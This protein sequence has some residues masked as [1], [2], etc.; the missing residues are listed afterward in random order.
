[1]FLGVLALVLLWVGYKLYAPRLENNWQINIHRSA[2]ITSKGTWLLRY[3]H[4]QLAQLGII[5]TIQSLWSAVMGV[6]YG[7]LQMIWIV[8]GTTF[9]GATLNYYGGIYALTHHGHSLNYVLKEKNKRVHL[10]MSVFLLLVL[11]LGT[12]CVFSIAYHIDFL[13]HKHSPV[14]YIYFAAM[15]LLSFCSQR[16]FIITYSIFAILFLAGSFYFMMLTAG[17]FQFASLNLNLAYY[18]ETRFTYPL[19]FM[20][21]SAGIMSGIDGLKGSILAPNIKN[22]KM[23]K[24]IYFGAAVAQA[25]LVILWALMLLAWNPEF[26]WLNKFMQR[27]ANPYEVL[28]GRLLNHFNSVAAMLLY[29]MTSVLCIGSGGTLLRLTGVLGRELG[30]EKDVARDFVPLG[31]F[32]LAFAL[33]YLSAKN[34]SDEGLWYQIGNTMRYTFAVA[35]NSFD[36]F[37]MLV[38]TY[39]FGL[40][41][42][43]FRQHEKSYNKYVYIAISLLGLCVAYVMM[44]W[45]HWPYGIDIICGLILNIGFIMAWYLYQ[46]RKHE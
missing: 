27:A 15:L 45:L 40:L 24:G 19:L 31:C 20:T 4:A 38:A 18:P 7:P 26:S 5:L 6:V 41:V 30:I 22:E 34:W 11:I 1:M 44:M 23:A 46:R 32:I 43:Y 16:K 9:L 21:V 25:G 13:F 8:L 17:E 29:V 14:V 37:N 10:W 42:M 3:R 36:L 33:Y 2:N 28:Q 39:V 12:S 35:M